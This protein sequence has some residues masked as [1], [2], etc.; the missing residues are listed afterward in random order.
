M[1]SGKLIKYQKKT[2][3]ALNILVEQTKIYTKT[4][5]E[6]DGDFKKIL[7]AE[8]KYKM[9]YYNYADVKNKWMDRK[10]IDDD[11]RHLILNTHAELQNKLD[12]MQQDA[13]TLFV[14]IVQN[15]AKF[16]IYI[17]TK[18]TEGLVAS[19][20][21]KSSFLSDQNK[22]NISLNRGRASDMAVRCE[23][24]NSRNNRQTL[25]KST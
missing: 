21:G 3:E 23:I 13:D 2:L 19:S 22:I 24:G 7:D 11:T 16:F 25:F 10:L 20:G 18:E 1:S 17:N 9:A 15:M 5:K 14:T 12:K 8:I 6:H 4:K